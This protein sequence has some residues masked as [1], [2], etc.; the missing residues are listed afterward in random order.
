MTQIWGLMD[1]SV[2]SVFICVPKLLQAYAWIQI[3][4][5]QVGDKIG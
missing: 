4:I 3:G 2:I 1:K 5:Q